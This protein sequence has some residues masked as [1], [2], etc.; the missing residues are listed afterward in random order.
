MKFIKQDTLSFYSK[1]AKNYIKFNQQPFQKFQHRKEKEKTLPWINKEDIVLDLGC[2]G[3]RS[4]MYLAAKAKKIIGLDG[5]LGMIEVA[6]SVNKRENIE[7]ILGDEE[8]LPLEKGYFRQIFG[9][10]S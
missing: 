4:S 7:Y 5:A 3:G 8:N 10:I 9:F 2:G 1:R 6:R